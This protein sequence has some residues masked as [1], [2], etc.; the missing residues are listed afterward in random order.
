[1]IGLLTLWLALLGAPEA[2]VPPDTGSTA[3]IAV[4]TD[5][6][7]RY[8]W[9][10]ALRYDYERVS[11]G[12][13][14]WQMMEA[15][16]QRRFEGGSVVV[17][18][19]RVRRFEAWDHALAGDLYV[20]LWKLAYGH[21]QGRYAPDPQ[22]LAETELWVELFQGLPSGWEVSA[23]YRMRNYP[24]DR[25]H[26]FGV[27]VGMYVGN[28]YL[29][30]E[31]VFIPI[32]GELGITETVMARRFLGSP[33]DY[34]ELRAGLGRGVAVI[35]AGPIVETTHTYFVGAR[36]Q[37]FVGPHLGFS[38]GANYS[39][40]DFFRRWGVRGGIMTRW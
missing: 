36:L 8:P 37:K 29:R 18:A 33:V 25:Y 24:S 19:E 13:P 40:D 7:E 39:D 30:E 22:S 23:S 26:F 3:P 12:R 35:G 11:D 27:G 2:P 28:W 31:T 10:V 5:P 9:E 34:W 16:V 15:A 4:D 1:M 6:R 21:V 14:D 17:Q 32:A 20:D 38:V